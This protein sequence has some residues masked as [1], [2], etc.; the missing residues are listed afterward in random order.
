VWGKEE[1][2]TDQLAAYMRVM[3]VHGHRVT[4]KTASKQEVEDISMASKR[5]AISPHFCA[6]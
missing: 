2:L 5:G 3:E 6:L 4:I 1:V